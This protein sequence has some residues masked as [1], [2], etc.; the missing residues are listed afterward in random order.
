MQPK[1][2]IWL[3]EIRGLF[4]PIFNPNIAAHS[5][6]K[7]LNSTLPN[8]VTFSVPFPSTFCHFGPKNLGKF[9][10]KDVLLV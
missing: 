7:Y 5:K 6:K 10:G 8:M 2:N 4:F 1:K 3:V 9:R